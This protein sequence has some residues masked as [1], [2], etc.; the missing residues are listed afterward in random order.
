MLEYGVKIW[1]V[2][3]LLADLEEEPAAG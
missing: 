1:G 2:A 3:G